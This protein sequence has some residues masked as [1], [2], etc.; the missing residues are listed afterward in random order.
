VRIELEADQL[1]LDI[2]QSMACGL[3]VNELV[4]NALKYAYPEE[5][6]GVIRVSLR[7]HP[8][9]ERVLTVADD[10]PGLAGA[11]K[12]GAPTL[13]MSLVVTLA[14]QLR[15]RV[16]VDGSRGTVVRVFFGR[17]NLEAVPA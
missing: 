5:R 13:G 12:G 8:G 17:K 1:E 9:G 3:I 2:D 16:E 11:K 4:T 15:G 10:G 6:G 7:E 14:R